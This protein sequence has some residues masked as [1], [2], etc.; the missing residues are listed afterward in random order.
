MAGFKTVYEW[1]GASGGD[2]FDNVHNWTPGYPVASPPGYGDLAI[3]NSG[4]AETVAGAGA[5][6]EA[7]V[8]LGTTLTIM[9]S[10]S[11]DGAVTGVGLM[12]DSGGRVVV[13]NGATKPGVPEPGDVSVDVIGFTGVGALDVGT[14]GGL[15]DTGMVLGDRTTGSG[16]L[17]VE[18]IVIVAP[19]A[20]PNGLLLVGNAGSGVV[21]IQNGG[22]LSAVT[23]TV[24]GFQSGS[25]GTATLTDAGS[26]WLAGAL[27]VGQAGTGSLTVQNGGVLTTTNGS[28]IGF[29]DAATGVH[30]T[31]GVTI[32][33]GG[34]LNALTSLRIGSLGTFLV[35]DGIASAS[36][37]TLSGGTV[38]VSNAGTVT[39]QTLTMAGGTIDVSNGGVLVDGPTLIAG[40]AG[41][42][43]VEAGANVNAL[44]TII[45]HIQ[46]SG[47]LLATGSAPSLLKIKG[48]IAGGG[49][50]APLM[51]LEI[52]GAIGAGVDI[53]FSPSVGAEVGDLVLDAPTGNQGTI[54]GFGIG[55]TIDVQ[56]SL[57]T[58]AVFTQGT[59]QTAGTLTLSGIGF[60]PLTLAVEG[61]YGADSFVAT[62]GT[63]D[64]IVTL[65]FAAGT[66]V[67]TPQGEVPIERLAVGDKALTLSGAARS[68]VWVGAGQVL[69]TRGRRTAA[70]PVIVRRG[71]LADNV[72]CRDLR[73]TKG[74]SLFIDGVL[75]PV[76]ELIN[77]R[78][79][80]WD[81]RA[82]ELTIYHV[83]LE[84]HDV[85]VANGAPAES[86][87]DDGNRWLFQNA[88]PDLALPP[89]APCAP[90]LTGGP[91]VDGIWRRL[92]DRAGPR[93]GV[94]LTDDP[95]LHLWVDGKRIDPLERTA[96]R[97]A[98]RLPPRPRSVRIRSRSTVPQE[99]GVA[100][101][102]R[103]LGVS[104]RR[105]VLAQAR[106]Q[107]AL[108][109]EAAALTEGWHRFEPENA[110]RWT[111]GDAALPVSIFAGMTGAGML[112]V[113]M[114]ATTQYIDDGK[115]E[116]AA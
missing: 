100:R 107:Q 56:G 108:D 53:A 18:G 35:N 52:Y 89:Q 41:T 95:D 75:I 112:I 39:T 60:A 65:C 85:L 79:I 114:G 22:A 33:A 86:Y 113:Q 48:D 17:T 84:T 80:F 1:I 70:T 87:R 20:A 27:T 110:L 45:G 34:M 57:Y 69:A 54:T 38:V 12:V 68:I 14:G 31:G 47:E 104:V 116:R 94:P 40:T 8:V 83:E 59:S 24:L 106:R 105:I 88:N 74:H 102:D 28:I 32:E 103:C 44:G 82:Q 42:V 5:A 19:A 51:T 98:F 96:E 6:S 78:S 50:L 77:H 36:A 72:P 93:R 2:W 25:N 64:T 115:A 15:D 97:C 16:T 10:L 30:G 21:T 49:I 29:D 71:A 111:D 76:E 92:L 91:V 43:F 37:I 66:H 26:T 61:N 7:D 63:S 67:A 73:I 9:D 58:D 109:A 23:G 62:P 46:L 101:D 4:I 11:L 13:G 90:V 81:D 55:N 3:F 99:L